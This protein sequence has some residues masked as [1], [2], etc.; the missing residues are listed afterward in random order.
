VIHEQFTPVRVPAAQ[1]TAMAG[2]VYPLAAE[3]T[4][5]LVLQGFTGAYFSRTESW[6][7][8][9]RVGGSVTLPLHRPAG[10]PRAP[11]HIDIN[12]NP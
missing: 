1:D 11:Q 5:G 9:A 8:Q 4:L 7:D 12:G 10:E 6:G 3:D 2:V